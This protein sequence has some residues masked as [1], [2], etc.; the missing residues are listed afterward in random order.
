M[1]CHPPDL[2]GNRRTGFFAGSVNQTFSAGRLNGYE[3]ALRAIGKSLTLGAALVRD[4]VIRMHPCARITRPIPVDRFQHW[5]K[6][7]HNVHP[8]I[9]EFFWH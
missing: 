3:A 8:K 4:Y 2:A 9:V 6:H 1:F 7:S 5:N